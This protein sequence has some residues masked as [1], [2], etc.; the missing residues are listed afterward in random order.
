MLTCS[1]CRDPHPGAKKSWERRFEGFTSYGARKSDWSSEQEEGP[2]CGS[3]GGGG[4]ELQELGLLLSSPRRLCSAH[5][6]AGRGDL[7]P[8]L[9]TAAAQPVRGSRRQD[10]R[11]VCRLSSFGPGLAHARA[12]AAQRVVLGFARLGF[13]FRFEAAGKPQAHVGEPDAL[14]SAVLFYPWSWSRSS[15]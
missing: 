7:Q 4:R 10:W 6:K 15:V 2:N 1:C 11:V 9:R 14:F 12:A 5:A 13:G 8:A 3:P